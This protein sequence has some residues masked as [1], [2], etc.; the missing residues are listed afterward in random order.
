MRKPWQSEE[1]QELIRKRRM[2]IT[3][4]ERASISKQIQKVSRR[5]LRKHQTA[6][7]TKKLEEF[8]DLSDLPKIQEY[9]I[10]HS[11]SSIEINPKSFAE[12]LQEIYEDPGGTISVDYEK[13]KDVPLFNLPELS[14]A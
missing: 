4:R 10:K 11:G 1:I 12:P 5:I 7:A 6:E 9:P 3:S 14:Y 8:S 13:I 2:C